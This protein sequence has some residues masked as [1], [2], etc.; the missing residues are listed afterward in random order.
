MKIIFIGVVE[1]SR[2][3]LRKMIELDSNLIGVLTKKKVRNK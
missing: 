3:I 1:F 2:E